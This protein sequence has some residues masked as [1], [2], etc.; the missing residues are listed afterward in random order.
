MF[1]NILLAF[2]PYLL[3]S[4]SLVAMDNV[5]C[6]QLDMHLVKWEIIY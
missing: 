3:P 4:F 5:G 2:T 1:Y 6:S